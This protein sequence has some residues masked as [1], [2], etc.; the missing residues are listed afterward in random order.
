MHVPVMLA[1]CL[2]Y[3]AI[4]PD[5]VY[6]DATCGLGG[7]S[8]AI[9]RKL[10]TGLVLACDRDSESLEMAKAATTDCADRIHF[11][12]SLFSELNG[13]LV[14]EK[15]PQLDGLLADL[16][17]SRYQLTDGGRGVLADGGRSVGHANGAR[18][19]RGC[20]GA[21]GRRLDC[22]FFF[23]E[24]SRQLDLR[25]RRGKEEQTDSQS[26]RAGA[27][28]SNH[29]SAGQ[30]DRGGRAPYG[31]N[32]SGN[33]NIYGVADRSESRVRGVGRIA[34]ESAEVDQTWRTSS[35]S[36]VSL[37]G[38][39]QGQAWIS[40]HGERGSREFTHASRRQACGTGSPG[41]STVAQR[42]ATC[43]GDV[44]RGAGAPSGYGSAAA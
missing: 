32:T 38:R 8:G 43:S 15:I 13:A 41:Q 44:W 29:R 28:D 25:V 2:D 23:R 27:A 18:R 10:T 9:A 12:Q 19:F 4:R 37:L 14:A 3:L 42:Q 26:N 6:L 30:A 31:Q 40:G 17:V 33:A 34:R 7:H 39:S 35:I 22:Q 5:G 11:H 36:D 24:G 1:E 16:G 20:R 21:S